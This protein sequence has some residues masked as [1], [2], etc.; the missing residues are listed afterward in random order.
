MARLKQ[1]ALSVGVLVCLNTPSVYGATSATSLTP[2]SLFSAERPT[3]ASFTPFGPVRL[4]DSRLGLGLKTALTNQVPANF[5]VAGVA[6]LPANTMAV[7]GNLTVTNQNAGGYV[8]LTTSPLTQPTTSTLNIAR[9]DNRA[10]G[11]Y[12]PLATDGSLWATAVGMNCA[13]VFDVTGYFTNETD[14]NSWYPLL[15][16][17]LSDTRSGLGLTGSFHR[18]AAR[19]LQVTGFGGVPLG[20][21][22]ITGNLTVVG[23]GGSGYLAVTV[24]PTN[25]PSTSTL[26]FPAGDTRANNLVSPLSSTGSLSLTYM[27]AGTTDI[28]FDVTGYFMPDQG[29]GLFVP[30]SP[31]RVLDSRLARPLAGPFTNRSPKTLNLAANVVPSAVALTGN[32]TATGVVG[33]G[34]AYVSPLTTN[35]PAT[36]NLNLPA[37]D[38]RANGLVAVLGPA[39]TINLGF[40]GG[41]AQLILDLTGYFVSPPPLVASAAFI[42]PTPASSLDFFGTPPTAINWTETGTIVS[43]ALARFSTPAAGSGCTSNWLA[44][45]TLTPTG[46]SATFPSYQAGYCYRFGLTLNGNAAA[47]ITSGIWRYPKPAAKV[48]VLMYHLVRPVVG[49]N[50][51]GL[52]VDPVTFNA[53]MQALHDAGWS[54]ITAAD[55]A[56]RTVKHLFIPDKTF[57]ATFDDGREDGY[58][59]AYPILQKYGFVASFYVITG[60]AGQPDNLSW[61]EMAVMTRAGMEIA[62]HTVSHTDVASLSASALASQIGGSKTAIET[63]LAAR[64]VNVI[65]TT[66]CYPYGDYSATAENYLG[67]HGF[68]AALTEIAGDVR[69]GNNMYEWPRLRVRRGEAASTL[70]ADMQNS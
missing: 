62:S 58:L 25:T 11:V 61:D 1:I 17:R 10:N 55:L 18:A 33:G 48:P 16:A 24:H 32:L 21:T 26:N 6:G 4:V 42:N 67:S 63:N 22:A 27:A 29:G 44:D 12:T 15:P 50:Q 56:N 66:F 49:D 5:A 13:L 69:P 20:A 47:T 57:V 68:L 43:R 34:Y 23:P 52:V 64:G 41:S 28:V 54:T 40:N 3:G 14:G 38:T 30:L 46:G 70:I 51:A 39:Q 37:G 36:S 53:Q 31:L 19:T 65:V 60:R 7:S 9:G 35:T 8:S 45:L 59:Y 2:P